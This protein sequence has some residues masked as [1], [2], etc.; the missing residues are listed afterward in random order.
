VS[1]AWIYIFGREGGAEEVL[2]SI[3]GW[4]GEVGGW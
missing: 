4:L 3:S 2:C 1:D